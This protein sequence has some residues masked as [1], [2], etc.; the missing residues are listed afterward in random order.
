M[1]LDFA[2]RP[3]RRADALSHGLISRRRLD[4]GCRLIRPGVCISNRATLT[5]MLRA[6][7]VWEWSR[8]S[9]V[10]SEV[11]A[12]AVLGTEYLGEHTRASCVSHVPLKCRGWVRIHQDCLD[13]DDIW[14]V[15]GMAV[16]SPV[17]TA[18]DVAR[19]LAFSQSVEVIDQIYQAT[20]LTREQLADYAVRHSGLH[21]VRRVPAAID[22]SDEGAESVWET[23]ARLAVIA[24]GLPR[25]RTQLEIRWPNGEFIARV[26]MCW[27]EYRV[28]FEYDGDG[29]HST[30]K[31]RDRDIERWNELLEAGY[32]VVRV[33]APQLMR[34]NPRVLSQVRSELRAAGADV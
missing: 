21:G 19:R 24:S 14:H 2:D 26:D 13:E 8:G 1:D 23:R 3:F 6:M 32:R 27:P 22:A 25:P 12:A 18:F 33:R 15:R 16:T 17:R 28:I 29:P 5:P 11:S 30:T 7:A 10:L 9:V 20:G 4:S 34:P 31:Q